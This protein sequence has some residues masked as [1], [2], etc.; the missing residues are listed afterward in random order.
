M[1]RV[2]LVKSPPVRAEDGGLIPGLEESL[3]KEMATHSSILAY[4][5]SWAEESGR[6]QSIG[7]QR[8]GHDCVRARTH[9]HKHTHRGINKHVLSKLIN[10]DMIY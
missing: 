10:D 8:V 6:L 4:E 3:E 7:L 5:I 9:A 1:A 2:V